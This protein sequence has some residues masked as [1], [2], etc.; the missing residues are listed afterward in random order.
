MRNSYE[1]NTYG[2]NNLQKCHTDLVSSTRKHDLFV[3]LFEGTFVH[4]KIEYE[5]NINNSLILLV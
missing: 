5:D 3:P 2:N 4:T 1:G